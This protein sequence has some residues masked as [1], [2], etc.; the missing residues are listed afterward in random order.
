MKRIFLIL[1]LLFSSLVYAQVQENTF[2]KP[3]GNYLGINWGLSTGSVRDMLTSPLFYTS[4]L[5]YGDFSYFYIDEQNIFEL[6][7]ATH[8]GLNAKLIS[9][10]FHVGFQ[11][12]FD[13]KLSLL[14]NVQSIS[15]NDLKHYLGADIDN[16]MSI[17]IMPDF[18]NAA[19][20][21]DNVSNF[22]IAYKAEYNYHKKR[23]E[24]N[25]LGLIPYTTNEKFYVFSGR[26]SVPVISLY[27][28]PKFTNPESATVD[29][30]DPLFKGY[31]LKAKAFSG[32]S[33][34]L[35]VSRILKNGNIIKYGYAWMFATNGKNAINRL[36]FSHHIIYIGLVFKFN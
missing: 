32:L 20:S 1:A 21:I 30:E 35:S 12:A 26:L 36:E 11:S 7:T 22:A 19:L 25:F 8:N 18:M 24:K 28:R 14:R 4:V 17:R 13:F 29:I 10:N 9:D 3:N 27:A 15:D 2:P 33:T 5:I 34:D 23:K 31:S 16:Y 6:K